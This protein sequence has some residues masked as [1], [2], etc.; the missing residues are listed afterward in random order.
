M[1]EF[2]DRDKVNIWHPI[3][4]FSHIS[5]WGIL[6]AVAPSSKTRNYLD[7]VHQRT[8]TRGSNIRRQTKC[9]PDASRWAST[10]NAIEK[11]SSRAGAEKTK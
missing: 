11:I 10:W 5:V 7:S 2:P 3:F 1:I 6:G 8:K 9:Q 4:T